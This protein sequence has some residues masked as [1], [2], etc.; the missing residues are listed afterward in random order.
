M[1]SRRVGGECQLGS[2]RRDSDSLPPLL[3]LQMQCGDGVALGVWGESRVVEGVRPS[4]MLK[5]RMCKRTGCSEYVPPLHAAAGSSAER[6]AS[7]A[8]SAEMA[9]L[10]TA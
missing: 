10:A 5:G 4:S 6:H 9:I 2:Q 8:L 1:I 7:R 3:Y